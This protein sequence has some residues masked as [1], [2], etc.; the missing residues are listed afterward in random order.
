MLSSP[1]D[2]EL[3]KEMMEH[4]FKSE[5]D[6]EDGWYPAIIAGWEATKIRD[7]YEFPSEEEE[8]V[9]L[10]YF[11]AGVAVGGRHIFDIVKAPSSS[12]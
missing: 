7:E 1:M 10:G 9:A 8:L 3:V 12:E 11:I 6:K 5:V 2:A 4:L